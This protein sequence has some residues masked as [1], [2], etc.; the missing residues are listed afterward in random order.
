MRRPI[1]PPFLFPK[2]SVIVKSGFLRDK[3]AFAMGR[4]SE[5]L[6]Q[7]KVRASKSM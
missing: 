6:S 5:C 2:K 1:W 3:R 4:I 7:G